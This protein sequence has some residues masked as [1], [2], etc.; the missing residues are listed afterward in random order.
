MP[1]IYL[2]FHDLGLPN[3]ERATRDFLFNHPPSSS[4]S[5]PIAPTQPI[6]INP[7]THLKTKQ[8]GTARITSILLWLETLRSFVSALA[9]LWIVKVW[10][11]KV[12]VYDREAQRLSL[13]CMPTLKR[14]LGF[15][16]HC[17][18]IVICIGN[19]T[20]E[21]PVPRSLVSCFRVGGLPTFC[22]FFFEFQMNR[23]P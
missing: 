3:I 18:C 8:K 16:K 13:F 19:Q 10:W 11:W 5:F 12:V 17:L 1:S 2:L 23:R 7:K 14:L 20:G 15:L 22:D 6:I 21:K 9:S 4:L